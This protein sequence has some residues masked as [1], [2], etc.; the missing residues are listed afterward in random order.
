MN[1]SFDPKGV[2]THRLSTTD[3][4]ESAKALKLGSLS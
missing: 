3:V 4:P 2:E 1:G